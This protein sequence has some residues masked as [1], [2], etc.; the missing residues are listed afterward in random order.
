MAP[1]VTVGGARIVMEGEGRRWQGR[2]DYTEANTRTDENGDIPISIQLFERTQ[3]A[4]PRTATVINDPAQW[5]RETY[6]A[7]LESERGGE[8]VPTGGPDEWHRLGEPPG[9]S[10]LVVL[11][12]S[13]SMEEN[14]RMANARAGINQTFANLPEDQL[15]EFAAVIFYGCGSFSTRSFTRDADSI[16]EFLVSASPSS[17]TPLAAAHDQAREMFASLADPRAEEW[18]YATFTDGAETCDGDVAGAVQRLQTLVN[19]H[20]APDSDPPP[21]PERPDP[22]PPPVDC[23]VATWRGYEVRVRDGGRHVDEIRLIEHAYL[24]RALPDGRCIARH[25]IDTYGVYYGSIRDR[26]GGRARSRWGVNSR[27]SETRTNFG[28]SRLGEDDLL[29]VRNEADRA[30]SDLVSLEDARN[31]IEQAVEAAQPGSG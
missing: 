26:S 4:D 25:Q 19:R 6:W 16:R 7:G 10:L 8:T 29:R 15:I 22:P 28:T 11:D 13:G 23:Q 2:F 31:R 9:L 21:E 1:Q 18:R 12:A 24:E 20:Q 27:P 17:G 5:R 30:R 3:D 14:N